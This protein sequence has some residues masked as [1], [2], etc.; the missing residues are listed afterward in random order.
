[1]INQRKIQ[2]Q[3][4]QDLINEQV[5]FVFPTNSFEGRDPFLSCV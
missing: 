2:Q 3:E 1:M 5:A 4:K